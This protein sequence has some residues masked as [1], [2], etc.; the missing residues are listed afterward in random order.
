MIEELPDRRQSQDALLHAIGN[1]E[2]AESKEQVHVVASAEERQALSTK[3]T[4]MLELSASNQSSSLYATI[5]TEKARTRYAFA[6]V[7][8]RKAVAATSVGMVQGSGLEGESFTGHRHRT[9]WHAALNKRIIAQRSAEAVLEVADEMLTSFDL[10]N[11]V[12]AIGCVSQSADAFKVGRDC[13]FLELLYRLEVLWDPCTFAT[14]EDERDQV[15]PSHLASVAAALARMQPKKVDGT[16]QRILRTLAAG[17][18]AHASAAQP[19]DL[20]MLSWA[21]ATLHTVPKTLMLSIACEAA[22]KISTFENHHI[23]ITTWAFGKMDLRCDLWTS[24]M[25]NEVLRRLPRHDFTP[26]HVANIAWAVGNCMMKSELRVG[27]ECCRLLLALADEA[28]ERLSDFDPQALNNIAWSLSRL[29]VRH[30]TFMER[31]A[32]RIPTVIGGFASLDIANLVY[33]FGKAGRVYPPLLAAVRTATAQ[34]WKEFSDGEVARI[35]WGLGVL[36]AIEPVWLDSAVARFVE[37]RASRSTTLP[38]L[39]GWAV[40][41]IINYSATSRGRLRSWAEAERYFHDEVYKPILEALAAIKS[42]TN[43]CEIN[44]LVDGMQELIV[45]LDID[46]LGLCYTRSLLWDLGLVDPSDTRGALAFTARWTVPASPRELSPSQPHWGALARAALSTAAAK[47]R[48]QSPDPSKT[49]QGTAAGFDAFGPHERRII[50]WLSYELEVDVSTTMAP[51]RRFGGCRTCRREGHVVRFIEDEQR[52]VSVRGERTMEFLAAGGGGEEL[53][54]A[55]VA[56]L[57][58]LEDIRRAQA[59]LPGLIAQHGRQGHCERQALLEVIFAV[60]V[61]AR[62]AEGD[63]ALNAPT[64]LQSGYF[65][66]GDG[67]CVAGEIRLYVAHF[68]CISCLSVMCHFAR[69]M[70]CVQLYVDYDDCWQT[71]VL[72]T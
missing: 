17:A 23:S 9:S 35:V 7:M 70:P 21:F 40:L 27:E 47:I 69:R 38:T 22:D 16:M 26:Q 33:A 11:T 8:T 10:Q 4:N 19:V 45:W 71:R 66:D 62:S 60:I 48:T 15:A 67:V 68:C 32:A 31:L 36:D 63:V 51:A 1:S 20:A 13:R 37:C 52:R 42:S 24:A 18:S 56:G 39:E 58:T 5:S 25:A 43:L 30:D 53:G 3:F 72:D 57:L 44:A 46:Y 61:A 41:H 2:L 65:G 59:W 14:Q 49:W 54:R 50:A 12:T 34:R 6:P 29:G 64:A 28:T 55:V